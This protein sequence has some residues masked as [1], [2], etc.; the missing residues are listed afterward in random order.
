MDLYSALRTR[1]QRL[2]EDPAISFGS[3]IHNS[4]AGL[5]YLDDALLRSALN[6]ASH[7]YDILLIATT[8][9]MWVADLLKPAS[10]RAMLQPADHVERAARPRRGS[11]HL[12]VHGL[13]PS[14]LRHASHDSPIVYTME[15]TNRMNL[16]FG[17]SL[18]R[19]RVACVSS[20]V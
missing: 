7:I 17:Q 4:D 13:L 6:S 3:S 18:L 10:V 12:H 2:S 11:V 1:Y 19:R 20:L 5:L 16:K 9:Q 14:V 8:Q 15:T